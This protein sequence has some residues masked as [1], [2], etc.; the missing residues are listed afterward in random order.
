MLR[1]ATSAVMR[2][3]MPVAATSRRCMMSTEASKA[4][5]P[6]LRVQHLAV[7]PFQMNQY[8]IGCEETK[9]A[10]LIDC[11]ATGKE[12]EALLK[13]AEGHEFKVTSILLTHAHVDHVLGVNETR[14]ALA[15]ASPDLL[16]PIYLHPD[17]MIGYT[18]VQKLA[19]GFGLNVKDSLP[20][21]NLN[22]I[23]DGDELKVGNLVFKVLHTPGHSPGHVCFWMKDY[24]L[25]FGGDLIFQGSIGRVDLPMSDTDQMTK[26]LKRITKD[27]PDHTV[28][29]PGHNGQT[30]IGQ[31]KRMNQFIN[32]M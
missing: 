28:I 6:P 3:A 27:I 26:S 13:W 24:G 20:V 30:T 9:E 12:L 7:G 1:P 21:S 32:W 2:R 19:E 10:A 31:E 23:N 16:V 25:M 11:G 4:D 17:E 18:N 22:P 29:M 14:E 15:G 5:D 8:I